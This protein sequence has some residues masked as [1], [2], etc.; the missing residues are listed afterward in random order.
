MNIFHI[1]KK[2]V[3]EYDKFLRKFDQEHPQKSASQ[4]KEIT[5]AQRIAKLR[6]DP[7]A[8]HEGEGGIWEA[9]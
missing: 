6:D 5:K 7:N 9:F 4:L 2:F 3:S 8:S 1:D